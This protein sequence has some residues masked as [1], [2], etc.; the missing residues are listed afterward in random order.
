[1]KT[2]AYFISCWLDFIGSDLS[3]RPRGSYQVYALK[4]PSP[5]PGKNPS[6]RRWR[7][8]HATPHSPQRLDRAEPSRGTRDTKPARDD[9]ARLAQGGTSRSTQTIQT[10]LLRRGAPRTHGVIHRPRN[11]SS[12]NRATRASLFVIT[13]PGHGRTELGASYSWEGVATPHGSNRRDS[14]REE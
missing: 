12:Q 11:D 14:V 7:R 3:H 8:K 2:I 13:A 1:M 4:K 9:L 10:R 5:W 6:R